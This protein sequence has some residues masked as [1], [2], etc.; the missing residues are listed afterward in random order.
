MTETSVQAL[1]T[2]V[3]AKATASAAAAAPLVAAR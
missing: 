2:Q 3:Q 1:I